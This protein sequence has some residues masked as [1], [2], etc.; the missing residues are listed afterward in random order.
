MPRKKAVDAPSRRQAPAMTPEE[1]EDQLVALAVDLSEQQ[2]RE[3][4]ASS[5]VIMHYLKLA[6]VR[7][8]LELEKIKRENSLLKAKEESIKSAERV[9]QL[10]A[11]AI[12]ALREYSG[13]DGDAYGD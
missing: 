8:K 1:R 7:E 5:Q 6:T 11:S 9:E 2:L 12:S 13:Y 4:T 3:G 10:Y